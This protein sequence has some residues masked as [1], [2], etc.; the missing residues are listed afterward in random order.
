MN[1][2]K[3]A[4][5]K[6]QMY[7]AGATINI[8]LDTMERSDDVRDFV[9]YNVMRSRPE[10]YDTRLKRWRDWTDTDDSELFANFQDMGVK[11]RMTVLAAFDLLLQ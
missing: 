5:K 11:S 3:G 8:L 4:G 10:R 2:Q 1:D 6:G 7:L 9:R